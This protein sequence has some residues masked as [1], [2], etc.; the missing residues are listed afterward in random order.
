MTSVFCNTVLVKVPHEEILERNS[1]TY[2]WFPTLMNIPF[3]EL[4]MAEQNNG[5]PLDIWLFRVYCLW[6]FSWKEIYHW[7]KSV[8]IDGIYLKLQ[9]FY[10]CQ[11][12][13]R[14]M[15]I[16]VTTDLSEISIW[17]LYF[18]STSIW[19]WKKSFGI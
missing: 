7:C 12:S 9:F 4:P 13:T 6:I 15:W 18:G 8:G 3:W 5:W 2:V 19:P 16:N 17:G 10:L 11:I 14:C 1:E